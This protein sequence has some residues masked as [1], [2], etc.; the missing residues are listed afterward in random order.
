MIMPSKQ[1]KEYEKQCGQYLKGYSE[2]LSDRLNLKCSY[3]MQTRRRVDLNNL[4][5]ATTD[6][7]TK[8]GILIDDNANIVSGFDGSRVLYDKDNPRVEIDI[9]RMEDKDDRERESET[10]TEIT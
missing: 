2:I 9:T 4:L 10:G 6:I 1:Y 7:L 5:E 8:Y 3:Y